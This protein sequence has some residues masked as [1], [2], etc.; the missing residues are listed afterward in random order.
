MLYAMFV[1]SVP[2]LLG[3]DRMLPHQELLRLGKLVPWN[4]SMLGLTL[5][6]SHQW[7]DH[8]KPDPNGVQLRMLQRVLLRLQEGNT[9]V[10]TNWQQQLA[11]NDRGLVRGAVW[12]D[13]IPRMYV[14]VD[15]CSMPQP[16]A[17]PMPSGHW[18]TEME[19]QDGSEVDTAGQDTDLAIQK[20]QTMRPPVERRLSQDHRE[21]TGYLHKC[22][23][24]GVTSLP[25]YIERSSIVIVL[26]LA[27]EHTCRRGEVC[28]FGSWRG[29]GWCR[30]ELAAAQLSRME[31]RLMVV[32]EG[33]APSS[34]EFVFPIDQ[35]FLPPG[36]G[37]F[38]CCAQD[39]DFGD[40]P[41]TGP[42]DKHKIVPVIQNLI[43]AKID[44]LHANG[45]L[46]GARF[47]TA[48]RPWLTRGSCPAGKENS[49]ANSCEQICKLRQ[50]LRWNG[51]DVERLKSKETGTSL[52]FWAVLSNNLP[53]VRVL[54]RND[55]VRA[56]D[57]NRRLKLKRP[58]LSVSMMTP[59]MFSA[60]FSSPEI[61]MALLEAGA[62]PYAQETNYG[63]AF[64]AA[65][66]H[67][68]VDNL[69]AWMN[70]F[71]SWDLERRNSFG[72]TALHMAIIFGP[73]KLPAVKYLLGAGAN[74]EA[75]NYFGANVLHL[76][77]I[78]IDLGNENVMRYLLER[79][80]PQLLNAPQHPQTLTW[81][82]LFWVSR[83][84]VSVCKSKG[85]FMQEIAA[86]QGATPL[87][88]ALYNQNI[89]A[90]RALAA[91]SG[92]DLDPRNAQGL[93]PLQWLQKEH[94]S[95]E[96]AKTF[97]APLLPQ[98]AGIGAAKA[99]LVQGSKVSQMVQVWSI[100]AIVVVMSALAAAL[101]QLG[102][103][104]EI[105]Q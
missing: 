85:K 88:F 77:T 38:S 32:R 81:R 25:A 3:L 34:I 49:Q 82:V 6:V 84:A 46:F 13:Q 41:G 39:H 104:I 57:V 9:D 17:G 70:R 2:D 74:I 60:G 50:A 42:C 64:M 29:R 30:L 78:N 61:V 87:H 94:G 20:D 16:T 98:H 18:L 52:L 100:A 56:N 35:L 72:N 33:E 96:L 89:G 80:P 28:D 76:A 4:E 65:A 103:M 43:E 7:L 54:L 71:P 75:V 90:V 69:V 37:V 68:R 83:F 91:V 47:F 24:D 79:S 12:R 62:D 14:W 67:G 36:R 58:D 15:Y 97:V 19:K 26:V 23:K 5:F 93:T 66:T 63:D 11:F 92:I 101:M 55:E 31:P 105:D 21:G 1:I 44:T 51:G 59:L 102:T 73:S 86:W 10:E 95:T 99:G 45:D 53:C 8:G 22:L 27:T 48:M 40:G